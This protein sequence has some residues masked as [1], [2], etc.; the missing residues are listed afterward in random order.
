MKIKTILTAAVLTVISANAGFFDHD[1]AYYDKHPEE[2]QSKFKLCEK[3]IVTALKSGDMALAEKYDKDPE[4]KAA[5]ISYK[6]HR[7][8]I[9][10]AEYEA[11][12]KEMEAKRAKKQAAFD[13]AYKAHLAKLQPMGFNTFMD[14]KKEACGNTTV[15]GDNLSIRNAK[16]KAWNELKKEKERAAIDDTIKQHPGDQL[17]A[18]EKKSCTNYSNPNCRIAQIALDKAVNE[19]KQRYLSDIASL[20]KDFNECQKKFAPLYL[21]NK[22]NEASKI[23]NTFKCKTVKEAAMQKFN[24]YS[25]LHPIK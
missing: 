13:Q 19:Q 7:A 3:G 11:E 24:T 12:R 2:A 4:C 21:N 10:K 18:Y 1:K 16:C 9:R 14:A 20:K 23:E 6:E 22:F 25:L 15:F 17:I 5:L 8:K